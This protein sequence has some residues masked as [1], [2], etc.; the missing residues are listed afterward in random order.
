VYRT[1]RPIKQRTP[2]RHGTTRS[3]E[4]SAC[5]RLEITEPED[6]GEHVAR[7][8]DARCPGSDRASPRSSLYPDDRRWFRAS[9]VREPQ[10]LKTQEK[11]RTSETQS[12]SVP[13][14]ASKT[15]SR[16]YSPPN[17]SVK[18]VKATNSTASI[19]HEIFFAEFIFHESAP[20]PNPPDGCNFQSAQ[21]LV[22]PM[23]ALLKWFV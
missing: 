8:V 23:G 3:S 13:T 9:R 16:K 18:I 17:P 1:T 19:Q 15:L 14:A 22:R 5:R 10:T 12:M 7:Q 21:P 11:S 4:E 2:A 20:N 6:M